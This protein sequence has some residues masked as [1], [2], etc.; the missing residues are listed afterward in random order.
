MFSIFRVLAT[1]GVLVAATIGWVVLGAVTSVRKDTAEHGL[2]ERIDELWGTSQAQ[3]PP[4]LTFN[5]KT[6][7]RE[8]TEREDPKDKAK[9]IEEW[10]TVTEEHGKSVPLAGTKVRAELR[11][12]LRRKGLRWYSLYGL[13]F[14]GTWRYQHEEPVEG[15]LQLAFRFPSPDGLYDDFHLL[16]DGVDRGRELEPKNGEVNLV[17]P[18]RPQQAVTIA[19][20]YKTRGR[21][22][23]RYEPADGVGLL[24]DVALDVTTDFPD[25]DFPAGSLSPTS[26]DRHEQGWR[27]GWRF[28]QVVTGQGL[29][30]VTPQRTQ[31]GEL[32]AELAFSAPISLIFFVGILF[33]LS[34]VRRIDVHPMNYLLLAG[35]FFAF[36]LLFA[37][38]ADRLPVEV[39]FALA[40]A[41][42]VALVIS[43]LR[44]VVSPDFAWREAGG[45]QL[46][47]LVGFSLAHF[48]KGVTG[49][50]VTILAV[51]TLFLVMQLTGRIRWSDVF[52]RPARAGA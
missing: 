28:A 42:S 22:E 33:I 25:I 8:R 41:V 27:L 35:A 4:A 10:T 3:R 40:S 48:W 32:A 15:W 18:V 19:V 21:D 16:V 46:V 47:Y 24:R 14:D 31:P 7:R 50:T 51:V 30:V 52:Q 38:T 13:T 17:V 1:L 49:L 5:W 11:S 6:Y 20:A 45:A 36:H 23:W 37:Y 39:A 9:K 12:D 44:L 26:K 43:Y 34:V 29:G 2:G